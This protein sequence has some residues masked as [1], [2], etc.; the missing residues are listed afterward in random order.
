MRSQRRL[1]VTIFWEIILQVADQLK[2]YSLKAFE[3]SKVSSGF[4][5]K[6]SVSLKRIILAG[7]FVR[8]D[9]LKIQ[10]H[11]PKNWWHTRSETSQLYRVHCKKSTENTVAQVYVGFKAEIITK[12]QT[13]TVKLRKNCKMLSCCSMTNDRTPFSRRK[14]YF[15]SSRLITCN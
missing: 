2:C 4:G 6:G 1:V 9:K 3:S 12:P 7:S 15:A 10:R 5:L 11:V 8:R 13:P 14:C